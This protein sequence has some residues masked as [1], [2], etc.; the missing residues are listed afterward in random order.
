MSD[1]PTAHGRLL[2]A[3]PDNDADKP[4]LTQSFRAIGD[5]YRY[6]APE[7]VDTIWQRT[8][9]A[10]SDLYPAPHALSNTLGSIFKTEYDAWSADR[11]RRVAGLRN[12]AGVA[13]V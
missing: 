7:T 8:A 13:A 9:T 12:N 1:P 10:L 3:I 11:D 4:A 6:A 2:H 5:S